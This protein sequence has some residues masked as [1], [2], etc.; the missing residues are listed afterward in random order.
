[1]LRLMPR[2]RRNLPFWLENELRQYTRFEPDLPS[3]RRISEQLVLAGVHD[4]HQQFPYRATAAL[5]DAL[6]TKAVD[7]AVTSDIARTQA[8][9]RADYAD[10]WRR[11]DLGR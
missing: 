2:I 7:W 8:N 6:E 10:F 3:L 9:S 5:A 11:N 1:M 4:S